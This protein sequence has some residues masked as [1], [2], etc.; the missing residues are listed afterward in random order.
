MR[1]VLL[2][3]DS[4]VARRVLARRLSAE[5]FFVHEASSAEAAREA[6]ARSLSCVIV[7]LEL[8]D[9]DGTDLADALLDQVASLPVA[10]F[11]AGAAPQVLDRA[12]TQGPVF[13]K[14]DVNA[15]VAWAMQ[16]G[17]PPPTK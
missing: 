10:F 4:A 5:G 8:A 7:D 6:D 15:I 9:G 16:A 12:R 11:T 1:T 2:V 3:D 17:Q 13:D 14:P